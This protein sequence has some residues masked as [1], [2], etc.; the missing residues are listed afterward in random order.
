MQL[1]FFSSKPVCPIN[2]CPSKSACP[3]NV[4][5]SN[6]VFPSNGCQS[7][8]I[9]PIDACLHNPRIVMK[10]LT[11]NLLLVLLFFQ[12]TLNLAYLA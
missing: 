11:F 9:S 8:P 10:T 5:S 4:S 12:R 6:H 1:L 3:G 7:K 2:I